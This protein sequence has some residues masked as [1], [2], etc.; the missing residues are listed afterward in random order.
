MTSEP[1]DGWGSITDPSERCQPDTEGKYGEK[2]GGDKIIKGE[3]RDVNKMLY[4]ML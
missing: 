2:R 4:A 3:I 1:P